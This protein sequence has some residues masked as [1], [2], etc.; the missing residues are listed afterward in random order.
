[1]YRF[2]NESLW[3]GAHFV[4]LSQ[5]V[6]YLAEWFLLPDNEAYLRVGNDPLRPRDIGDKA[7]WFSDGLTT[8]PF[9]LW[10][11]RFE[12][13][14]LRPAVEHIY[15]KLRRNNYGE[16]SIFT[17][18]KTASSAADSPDVKKFSS[19]SGIREIDSSS[20]SETPTGTF[21]CGI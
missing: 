10:T 12:R 6:E 8:V 3:W 2:C 21:Q 1:M 13:G 9:Q 7:R 11:E 4:H 16:S 14:L 17:S 19:T 20:D 15:S 5:A 18:K